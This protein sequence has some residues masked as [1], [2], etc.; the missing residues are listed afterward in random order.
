MPRPPLYPEGATQMNVHIPISLKVVVQESAARQ[1]LSA[2]QVVRI[3]LET[4]LGQ[5]GELPPQ[6][7]EKA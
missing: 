7:G 6:D 1:H 5:R 3:A 2:S 4:Y